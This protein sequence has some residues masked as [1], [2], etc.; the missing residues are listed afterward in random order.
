MCQ[1]NEEAIHSEYDHLLEIPYIDNC[2]VADSDTEGQLF[3]TLWPQHTRLSA[4]EFRRRFYGSP[5]Q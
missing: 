1:K 5:A 3:R 4:S 2:F